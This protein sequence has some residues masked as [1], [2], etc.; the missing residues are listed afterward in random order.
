MAIQ[1]ELKKQLENRF[2][3]RVRF[4]EPMAVH[5]TFR[6]G[7]PADAF[8]TV[9]N[10]NEL[11]YLVKWLKEKNLAFYIIGGGSNLLVKDQGIRGVVIHMARGLAKISHDGATIISVM[12]GA[13]LSAL[14][15]YAIHHGLSGLN[16]AL[17]IPGTV[18]GAIRMNAGAWQ[19]EM[20]DVLDSI[21]I[22]RSDGSI[23]SLDKTAL[24]FSYRSLAFEKGNSMDVSSS[25]IL[26]GRFLLSKQL[27]EILKA[28][29][30]EMLKT[31]KKSQPTGFASAGCF[32]KNPDKQESAGK[33][34]DLAGGKNFRVGDAAVSAE[35]ANFIVNQ[36]SATA[37]DILRL[38][39]VVQEA[40]LKK[41]NIMLE[42]EVKIVGN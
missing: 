3:D 4:N 39:D 17:G 5:T 1:S 27:T 35:H 30:D 37:E 13:S 8:V 29:A 28:E 7:G 16:F 33:L 26:E 9:N 42:P 18:G 11:I 12:A 38:M 21:R 14:C 36:G 23:E 32:F 31:R 22:I 34:I 20:G 6:V 19:C 40:V 24:T 15:R 10:E 2:S 25:V 41:F